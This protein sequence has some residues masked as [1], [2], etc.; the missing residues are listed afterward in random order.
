[1]SL[2]EELEHNR[3]VRRCADALERIATTLEEHL[4]KPGTLWDMHNEIVRLENEIRCTAS[5]RPATVADF[6]K[7]GM[8][9][10]ALVS[11]SRLVCSM[12]NRGEHARCMV[13]GQCTC[14]VCHQEPTVPGWM[15]PLAIGGHSIDRHPFEGLEDNH[16]C[17]KCGAGRLHG[18]HQ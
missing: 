15:I 14:W 3:Q 18:I 12:C 16:F 17:T 11:E 7:A 8:Q 10:E 2:P 9:A 13:P 1:M 6:V 5:P 4:P